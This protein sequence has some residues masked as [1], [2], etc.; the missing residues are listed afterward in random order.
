MVQ[1]ALFVRLCRSG[2]KVLSSHAH[3]YVLFSSNIIFHRQSS[4]S[5]GK[6]GKIK[7]CISLL[8]TKKIKITP[9]TCIELSRNLIR[10]SRGNNDQA[11]RKECA[12]QVLHLQTLLRE[13]N[14]EQA[15][16]GSFWIDYM[17]ACYVIGNYEKACET[18]ERLL[19]IGC[20]PGGDLYDVYFQVF[21]QAVIHTPACK[22]L[23]EEYD[24]AKSEK[25]RIYSPR[26]F[27]KMMEANLSF[28]GRSNFATQ[29]LRD[30]E[31]REIKPSLHDVIRV[32]DNG[33]KDE[34][35]DVVSDLLNVLGN[36]GGFIDQG[37]SLRILGIAARHNK[38]SLAM[39]A[40]SI[41]R[42]GQ[43]RVLESH[44]SSVVHCLVAAGKDE[45]ALVFLS[46]TDQEGISPN[47][48][49][50]QSIG[51]ILGCSVVRLDYALNRIFQ[52][53]RDGDHVAISSLNTL[54]FGCSS[55][56]NGL[57]MDRAFAMFDDFEHRF[58]ISPN[59]DTYNA[60]IATCANRQHPQP[61]A[62]NFLF[63]KMMEAG[64]VA[65]RDTFDGLVKSSLYKKDFKTTKDFLCLMFS[66]NIKL[67]LYTLQLLLHEVLQ[68]QQQQL[69]QDII[70]QMEHS[71]VYTTRIKYLMRDIVV[72]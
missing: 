61:V 29:I 5:L 23:L 32:L 38:P 57:C 59:L 16:E 24:R 54:L 55:V 63:V 71:D 1:R 60:L 69:F 44:V 36:L 9:D 12:K 4:L 10:E 13:T 40:W 19:E 6:I 47:S 34:N 27:S 26:I 18:H 70:S 20:V 67:P 42:G 41:M 7:E 51:R 46:L 58:K 50:L 33:I 25:L 3:R 14:S 45:E 48:K 21:I 11:T 28:I 31:V 62:A 8:R 52:L 17:R 56:P 72:M 68:S 64:I 53:H 2:N 39:K 35:I 49:S 37:Q 30:M 22:V 66:K 65:T 43:V 15:L